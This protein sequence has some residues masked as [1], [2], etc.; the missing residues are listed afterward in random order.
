MR[1]KSVT[2]VMYR[3]NTCAARS[4]GPLRGHAFSCTADIT[5]G[6]VSCLSSDRS[7]L[8]APSLSQ[9]GPP[10]FAEFEPR[11]W[12]QWLFFNCYFAALCVIVV[13][14]E[15]TEPPPQAEDPEEQALVA[16]AL[17]RYR[18]SKRGREGSE[19]D[20]ATSPSRVRSDAGPSPTAEP[21]TSGR[22]ALGSGVAPMG[23]PSSPS[24]VGQQC[25]RWQQFGAC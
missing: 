25:Q 1:G 2:Y 15:T 11:S 5:I 3:S 20:T 14:A 17:R 7:S 24:P 4:A 10:G 13:I 22:A 23:P 18:A 9:L 19:G 16:E 12:S 8:L 21:G 6:Y